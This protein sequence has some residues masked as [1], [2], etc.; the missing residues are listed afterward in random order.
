MVRFLDLEKMFTWQLK[1]SHGLFLLVL[2]VSFLFISTTVI[3]VAQI[4]YSEELNIST[5]KSSQYYMLLGGSSA[6]ARILVGR[7]C[8]IKWINIRFVNQLGITIT[9]V[10]TCLLPLAR[11]FTS[12]V[13]YS[14]VFGFTDGAFITSQNVI[15]LGIVGPERRASAFGFGTM[16]CS[17]AVASGPPLAGKHGWNIHRL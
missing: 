7:L 2:H 6:A 11:S 4:K 8:D 10:A 15:L 1:G 17:F 9:G 3:F 5:S 14:A 12:V 13:F 16:L